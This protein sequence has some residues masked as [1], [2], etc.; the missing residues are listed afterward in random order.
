MRANGSRFKSGGDQEADD[1]AAEV[2]VVA[3][4]T[5]MFFHSEKRIQEVA[6]GVQPARN[7]NRIIKGYDVAQGIQQDGR[8]NDARHAARSAIS[9]ILVVP[10]DIQREQAAANDRA[11]INQE[12]DSFAEEVFQ[13]GAEQVQAHHVEDQVAPIGMK[14]RGRN[15]AMIFFAGENRFGIKDVFLGELP[16]LES[17]IGE[18]TRHHDQDKCQNRCVGH[19]SNPGLVPSETKT[20]DKR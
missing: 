14:K 1:C 16:A 8:K 12:V 11:K 13:P 20:K 4:V 18:D 6:G 17:L 2:R 10:V 3:N 7:R 9:R 19:G 5:A 15:D